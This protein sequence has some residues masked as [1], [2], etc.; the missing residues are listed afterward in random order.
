MRSAGG[1]V[2]LTAPTATVCVGA[3]LEVEVDDG[4]EPLEELCAN[5][6]GSRAAAKRKKT[7]RNIMMLNLKIRNQSSQLNDEEDHKICR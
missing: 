3:E 5:P 1:A 7:M 4:T 6:E 2:R